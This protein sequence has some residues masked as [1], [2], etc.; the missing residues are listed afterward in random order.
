[1]MSDLDSIAVRKQEFSAITRQRH[2]DATVRV[3]RLIGI[4]FVTIGCLGALL[5]LSESRR[6]TVSAL[7]ILSSLVI[8]PGVLYIIAG[9][10]LKKRRYWAWMTTVIMTLLLLLVVLIFSTLVLI[11]IVRTHFPE[12]SSMPAVGFACMAIALTSILISLRKCLPAVLESE[13]QAQHG[14][15]V[16]PVANLAPPSD[17]QSP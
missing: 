8:T 17:Q 12:E 16:I 4:L 1:M 5:I 13:Q 14:F 10:F 2:L 7:T 3:T 15:A 11:A 6:S 9:V